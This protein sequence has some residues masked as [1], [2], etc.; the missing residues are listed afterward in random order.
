MKE[1]VFKSVFVKNF[2]SIGNDP[3]KLDFN[4]GI[5]VITGEN[6]DK[7]G[8]NGIGK[9]TIADS[10]FWCLFGNTIRELKKDKIQHNQ[11]ENEC[12]VILEFD[13]K[14]A[15]EIK[16]YKINR[17][18][19]PSK[20]QIFCDNQD[21]TLSTLPKND[22]FIKTIINANEEVFNN[23]VIMSA[24]NTIPF[25]AQKK[26][27]KRKF[28]EGILQLNIFSEMLLK[29]RSDYNDNKKENDH[30]S[31]LYT[32]HQTN[33]DIFQKQKEKGEE[34]K[35]NKIKEFEN[36]IQESEKEIEKL[37]NNKK[38]I[39]ELKKQKKEY[40][41]KIELLE[42]A[43]KK[44]A[45]EC[46]NITSQQIKKESE[47]NQKEKE[48]NNLLN[49]GNKCPT[50]N[51]EYC[52]DDIT[53][54]S[55]KIQNISNEINIL[56]QELSDL[57][58]KQKECEKLTESITNGI[59]KV[60]EKIDKIT[61]EISQ[62]TLN[63][64]K[65]KNIEDKIKEYQEYIK[66]IKEEKNDYD[67]NI[68]DIQEKIKNTENEL[69]KVK[70]QLKILDTVKHIV[71]EDGVKTYIVKKIINVLNNRLN[72]Y[73]QKLDTPCKCVFDESFDEIIYNEQGK[74][75]SYFNFSGGERK[76]IDTA[77]LFT[78]QDV[79]RFHSGTSFS[80]N[81]YDELFD[82]ALDNKGTDKILD[83]LK[84]KV[85]KYNESI[86]IVSHKHSETSNINNVIFLQKVNGVTSIVD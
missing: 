6:K 83:I 35:K 65:I 36:K 51:R 19:N 40:V 5:T 25:M 82:C 62:E 80:L 67:K 49:K 18:L 72:Y 27:E 48:K 50:C 47:I 17:I 78:F 30:L 54:V 16:N 33:L 2:L 53:L 70:T 85:D 12:Q 61:E 34:N 10:I 20:I 45:N 74:E 69:K 71:S 42:K 81:I 73:L 77:I 60:K 15:N 79:M 24:N 66:N 29:T 64:Q 58:K 86:Y 52:Q 4:Q 56:K 75:V 14:T 13:I 22:D 38:P 21:I 41:E 55:Q 43:H 8:K 59:R 23:A 9:S 31:G 28:I 63:Q 76:R 7:G 37:K 1:I 68:K 84:E 3:I 39:D 46:K 44:Q 26:T 57:N 11:N 32:N